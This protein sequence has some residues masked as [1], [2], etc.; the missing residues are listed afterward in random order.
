MLAHTFD[1]RWVGGPCWVQ[2]KFNGVRAL[3]QT[4]DG[5][6]RF[7]SRDEHPW[8]PAVLEHISSV[9]QVLFPEPNIILDGELYCHGWPLQDINAAISVNRTAPTPNTKSIYYVVFDRY[10]ESPFFNR[11]QHPFN[12]IKTANSPVV[13]AATTQYV[14]SSSQADDFY[15][16]CIRDGFEGM[17]YRIGICP[18]T[19]P[20][21]PN[22][23][24]RG[25]LSDKNNRTWH[26]LKRKAWQDDEFTCVAVEEGQG[27]RE[28]MV[29]R[30][31]CALPNGLTFGVGSGLSDAENIKYFQ[32]PPIGRQIKVKFLCYTSDGRPFNPTIEAIL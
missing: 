1:G 32:E 25:F 3:Y 2:P 17:M 13:H 28:G 4:V 10:G 16:A 8:H 26:L 31:V 22:P 15:A 30:F 18:Y 29:G 19:T 12:V 21:Q 14:T 24:G 7:Q 5:K 23:T 27:K 20:K 11:I 6:G 9:L